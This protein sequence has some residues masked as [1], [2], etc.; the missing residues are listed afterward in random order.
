MMSPQSIVVQANIKMCKKNKMSNF[1]LKI[2]LVKFLEI[3]GIRFNFLHQNGWNPSNDFFLSIYIIA[4]FSF[5]FHIIILFSFLMTSLLSS[6]FL[7][8]FCP[9]LILFYSHF[10]PHFPY[11]FS[12]MFRSYSFFNIFPLNHR[13][14]RL[15][16]FYKC[17]PNKFPALLHCFYLISNLIG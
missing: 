6:H 7:C 8:D 14:K 2:V 4:F 3:S 1:F 16:S 9:L 11:Q 13:R 17:Y 10:F 12:P 5:F 15:N